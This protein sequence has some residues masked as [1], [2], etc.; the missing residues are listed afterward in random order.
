MTSAPSLLELY[1]RMATIRRAEERLSKPFSEG[2]VPGFLHLSIGQEAVPV[3]ICA[4]V[5]RSLA[6]A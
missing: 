4:A 5:R 2:E 6:I 1:G 3:G